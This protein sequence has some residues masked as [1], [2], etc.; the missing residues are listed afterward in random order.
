M[1][2][3]ELHHWFYVPI[4]CVASYYSVQAL[5]DARTL[6][7]HADKA[8]SL[9]G[10]TLAMVN[11]TLRG[12]HKNGDDGLLFRASLLVANADS[13]TN[14]IKQASQQ[15]N[16]A[17]KENEPKAG[18]LADGSI[19]AVRSGKD[20]VD[21]LGDALVTLNEVIALARDG[22]LPKLNASIDNLSQAVAGLKPVED[23]ASALLASGAAVV[24]D[25]DGTVKGATA[26][27]TNADFAATAANL[28]LASASGASALA[29]V[30]KAVGYIEQDLSPK[31]IPLWQ[32]LVEGALGNL[33]SIP[34]K[35]I[36]GNVNVTNTVK[37][38]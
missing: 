15:V 20:A 34:F 3:P 37:T 10:D 32:T 38:Q 16:K 9:S 18:A 7:Q 35:R 33:I 19:A 4:V 5:R 13:A 22:T 27:V 28:R 30:D 25:L 11:A 23:N 21:K 29:H 24:T 6:I 12:S 17:S 14:A 2:L 36:P 26:L 31:H 1:K 8:V